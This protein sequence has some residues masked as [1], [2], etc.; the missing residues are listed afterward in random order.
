MRVMIKRIIKYFY[1]IGSVIL[2]IIKVI[3]VKLII[4]IRSMVFILILSFEKWYFFMNICYLSCFIKEI[5]VLKINVVY[6]REI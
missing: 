2:I 5:L 6:F 4:I 1:G 3:K